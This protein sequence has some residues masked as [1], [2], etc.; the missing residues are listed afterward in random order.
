M[1]YYRM[2]ESTQ[3]GG[4]DITPWLSWFL[5]CLSGALENADLVIG[6]AIRRARFWDA[7]VQIAFNDRQRRVL[8]RLMEP[9]EGKL[10]TSKYAKLAKCS[11][12]TALR[13]LK[14]LVFFGILDTE[15][16]GRGTH[17]VWNRSAWPDL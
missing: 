2:L 10:T 1:S 8:L 11:G 5:D 4:L 13:D 7:H 17:Y 6:Q 15:G 14:E 3:R 12:D 16:I 9:F